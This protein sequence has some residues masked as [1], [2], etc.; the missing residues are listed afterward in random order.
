MKPIQ[1]D[2]RQLLR[3]AAATATTLWLPRS[4]WSRAPALAQDPFALGVA[5]GAPAPD[6]VVLW[7]R[8]VFPEPLAREVTV[9]WEVAHDE[10]FTRIARSG[11]AQ[12]VPALGHAVHAEVQGLESDRW[13]FY[14]FWAG[15]AGSPVGRT[16]TAPAHGAEVARLRV[17]YASCQRWEHGYYAAWRHLRADAPDLVVFLGDYIYEYPGAQNAVRSV[18]GGWVLTLDDYRDRYALHRSDADLRAMHAACPWLLTW[19]DHEVQNDYAALHEGTGV[20]VVG[21][22]AD[23]AARRAAAYQA[24]YEHMPVRAS[25]LTRGLSGLAQGAEMRVHQQW[26]WGRLATLHLLDGRQYRDRQPCLKDGKPGGTLVDPAQCAEWADTRR[27]YLGAAQEQ[28][29]DQAL[30]RSAGRWNVIGQQTLFGTRDARPG[31]GQRLWNDGWDG[32]AGARR[33]LTDALQ[34]HRVSNPVFL[35]GDVHENW[36][37]HVKADYADADSVT[38]GVEFCGTSISSRAS[39]T[40]VERTPE[41]LAENPHFVFGDA[42]YRGYGLAD[43]TP[44]GLQTTLRAV[45]DVTRAD[46]AAFTLAAFEVRE[47]RARIERR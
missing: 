17:G 23:F 42:Q 27:T 36:V 41:R 5:S 11:V 43:F 37:G 30:A 16:R 2:R 4:A 10:A 9:R 8:L 18:K 47:G 14:R 29:L 31:P 26:A 12:A 25:V 22:V 33:R 7:T 20:P 39:A 35:G 40:A 21:T 34:K 3:L 6:G 44:Q 19:D 28:W 13:Y 15:E 46:S 24:W 38:L 32:Y 45:E 1:T